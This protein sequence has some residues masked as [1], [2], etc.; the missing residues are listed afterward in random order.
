MTLLLIFDS[1]TVFSGIGK[2][3]DGKLP[4]IG[5][6]N[7][8]YSNKNILAS[9]IFVKI[10]FALWLMVFSRKWLGTLGILGTL[11]AGWA[12]IRA[13]LKNSSPERLALLFLPAFGLLCYGV[14][15]FFNF[16]QDR[17]EMQA[18]FALYVGLAVAVTS[19][20]TRENIKP[21]A[22]SS[23][24]KSGFSFFRLDRSV[25]INLKSLVYINRKDHVCT[26]AYNG[27]TVGFSISRIRI[28]Q[29]TELF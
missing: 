28:K 2:Y 1:L 14:D 11:L 23:P 26:L 5:E 9:S 25:I 7:S 27:S 3:L 18:L 19:L 17:P 12:F 15:A 16:P 8:V 20:Y 10:P 29:L 13:L 4:S 22:Y 6:L 24:G 21:S